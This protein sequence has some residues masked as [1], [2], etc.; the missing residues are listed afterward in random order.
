M[1]I[2]TGCDSIF[3][4]NR[5][6]TNSFTMKT[7]VAMISNGS[8]GRFKSIPKVGKKSRSG[9]ES[10]AKKTMINNTESSE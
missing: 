6:S 4:S 5:C 3:L 2:D 10:G 8:V 7:P 1:T 9:I